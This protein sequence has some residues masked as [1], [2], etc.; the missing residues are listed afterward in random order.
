MG[1]GRR[2]EPVSVPCPLELK[3]FPLVATFGAGVISMILQTRE[4][5]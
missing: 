3:V 5:R 2:R 1:G 4:A